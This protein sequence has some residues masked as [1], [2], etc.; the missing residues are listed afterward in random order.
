MDCPSSGSN[1]TRRRFAP[2]RDGVRAAGTVAAALYA[3]AKECWLP[4]GAISCLD[5]AERTAARLAE[6]T[7]RSGLV[8]GVLRSTEALVGFADAGVSHK[9]Q[10]TVLQSFSER[11]AEYQSAAKLLKSIADIFFVIGNFEAL[12]DTQRRP[13]PLASSRRRP[14]RAQANTRSQ[15]E[16][17]G[18]THPA[19]RLP[20][21]VPERLLPNFATSR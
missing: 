3:T 12:G 2:V 8:R 10:Y 13:K 11:P 14:R 5:E 4:A 9:H 7:R 20:D 15:D 16:L 17:H 6:P 18:V 19:A 1:G 21:S